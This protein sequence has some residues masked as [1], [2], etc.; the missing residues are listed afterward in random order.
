MIVPAF[1]QQYVFT[2]EEFPQRLLKK[3]KDLFLESVNLLEKKT[4]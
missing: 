3:S 2:L 4:V 1:N